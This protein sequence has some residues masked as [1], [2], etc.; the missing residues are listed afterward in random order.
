MEGKKKTVYSRPMSV[1]TN[2]PSEKKYLLPALE[3]IVYLLNVTCL[4]RDRKSVV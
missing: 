2:I 4:C 3:E 1:C